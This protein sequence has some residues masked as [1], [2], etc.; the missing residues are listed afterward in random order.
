MI[1][2][3]GTPFRPDSSDEVTTSIAASLAGR[4]H[5]LEQSPSHQGRT[6]MITCHQGLKRA[7]PAGNY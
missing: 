1:G 5:R 6:F 7:F 3:S 4:R 2:F